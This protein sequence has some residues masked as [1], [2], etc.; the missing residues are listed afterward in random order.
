MDR[1]GNNRRLRYR[2]ELGKSL[3]RLHQKSDSWRGQVG[4]WR[5]KRLRY[6]R[7]AL[8]YAADITLKTS[9]MFVT[10]TTVLLGNVGHVNAAFPA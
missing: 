2:V 8:N 10:T 9:R 1:E 6:G 3:L 7:Q 5:A 4:R